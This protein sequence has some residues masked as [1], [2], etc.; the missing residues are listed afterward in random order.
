MAFPPGVAICPVTIKAPLTFGGA[1]ATVR[2]IVTPAI[3]LVWTATGQ[4]FADFEEQPAAVTAGTA[5]VTLPTIQPGFQ[6]EA[7][8]TVLSWTYNARVQFTHQGK[9]RHL[10]LKSFTIPEGQSAPIDLALIPSGPAAPVLTAPSAT[11]TSINGATGAVDTNLQA[12]RTPEDYLT[13]ERTLTDGAVTLA[14]FEWPDGTTGV[15]TGTPSVAFPG[16]LDSYSITYG[17]TRTYT[18]PT[19]T[20]DANGDIT[21]QP[22]IVLS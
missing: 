20:R 18:Q 2:L 19:V 3:R 16:S 12:A 17:T 21:N 8:N 15:F 5:T 6:D 13:G 9:T 7:G 1:D 10:P 4:P 14:D 11:V 22:A